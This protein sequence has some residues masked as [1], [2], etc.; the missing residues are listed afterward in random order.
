[1]GYTIFLILFALSPV[2]LI[3]ALVAIGKRA[4]DDQEIMD[5]IPPT[6]AYEFRHSRTARKAYRTY[7]KRNKDWFGRRL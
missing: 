6:E 4:M 7:A 2:F 3:V 1:M 5:N